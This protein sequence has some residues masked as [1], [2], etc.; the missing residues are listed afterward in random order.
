[1]KNAHVIV[2][3][4]THK[5]SPALRRRLDRIAALLLARRSF[6]G[7]WEASL[8]GSGPACAPMPWRERVTAVGRVWPIVTVFVVVIGGIYGGVFTP[9]EAAAI[10][11]I[12]TTLFP[13]LSLWLV[14]ALGG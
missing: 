11:T 12:A 13:G 9:T 4:F 7:A 10:G 3:L 14:H 5:A 1:M 2:D 6:V 8:P